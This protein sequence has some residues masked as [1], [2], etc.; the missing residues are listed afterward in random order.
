MLKKYITK[1]PDGRKEQYCSLLGRQILLTDGDIVN[2]GLLTQI[3]KSYFKEL[4]DQN[5]AKITEPEPKIETRYDK[6]VEVSADFDELIE[7]E[8]EVPETKSKTRK[9]RK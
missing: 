2:D 1:L 9:T 7:P 3:Y 8:Q 6:I 5:Q 4:K